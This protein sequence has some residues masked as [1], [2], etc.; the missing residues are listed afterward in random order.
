MKHICSTLLAT[1]LLI[2]SNFV[3]AFAAPETAAVPG[4]IIVIDLP[5]SKSR[6]QVKY[7]KRQIMVI[8][9]DSSWKAIVGIPLTEKPGTQV[10]TVN[11]QNNPSQQITFNIKKKKYP[12][13]HIT[14]KNKRMVNPNQYDMGRIN[15]D[16]KRINAALRHWQYSS[17]VQLNFIKP[18]QGVYSSA[19]GLRRFFNKQ[20]RK[21]HSGLDIAAAEGS[22]IH[23]P[24][25]GTII[26]TGNYFFNGNTLFIDHGQGLISMYCHMNS[27]D[28]KNGSKV[29]QGQ[30]IGK[31]GKT[32]RVTGPHLHW[33]ISLNRTMVDPSLFLSAGD[34]P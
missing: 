27:I 15:K 34:R 3:S 14:I 22:P 1:S 19:F 18:V 33:S 29:K 11:S 7:K 31:V 30:L 4:G 2:S 12:E 21:P 5:A 8:N 26:E 28:I 24:A 13:Q 17:N 20:A 32:G 10:I 9:D 25:N 6:P 23:A 16:K